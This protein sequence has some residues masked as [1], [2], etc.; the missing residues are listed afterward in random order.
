VWSHDNIGPGLWLDIDNRAAVIRDNRVEDNIGAGIFYE[1]SAGPTVIEDN[2]VRGNGHT[3]TDRL[4]AGI[5]ISNSSNVTVR[6]NVLTDNARGIAAV[7]RGDRD[8]ATGRL[9]VIDNDVTMTTGWTGLD[10]A[11]GAETMLLEPGG[12]NR[13]DGNTYRVADD[14]A[15]W[16]FWDGELT[17]S[18]WQGLGHDAGGRVVVSDP[19][20]PEPLVGFRVADYGP[21]S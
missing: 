9:V 6:G 2:E 10:L 14:A 21:R 17:W 15:R 18:Q 13:F 20:R 3:D 16:W 7:S 5:L 1:I 19:T 12:G 11:R 4:T 8:P